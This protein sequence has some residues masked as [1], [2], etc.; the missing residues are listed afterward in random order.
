MSKFLDV[1]NLSESK[2]AGIHFNRAFELIGGGQ[3]D[4]EPGEQTFHIEMICLVRRG[5]ASKAIA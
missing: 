4:I 2:F 1:K 3:N 5:E